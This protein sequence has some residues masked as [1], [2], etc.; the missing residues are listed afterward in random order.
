M[1]RKRLALVCLLLAVGVTSACEQTQSGAKP[2][3]MSPIT[4]EEAAQVQAPSPTGYEANDDVRVRIRPAKGDDRVIEDREETRRIAETLM[5][6]PFA[7]AK[8]S[9]VRPPDYAIEV[10]TENGRD[11]FA[12]EADFQV[13]I[14]PS[15]DQ[16]EIVRET[17]QYAKLT[18]EASEEALRILLFA[19]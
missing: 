8:V 14:T 15:L 4:D 19:K 12:I 11:G 16:L 13:W 17:S 6:A 2:R 10:G 9:M 7:N 5:N 1:K 3:A 18:P